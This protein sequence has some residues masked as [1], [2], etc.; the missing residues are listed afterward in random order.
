MDDDVFA[1]L[2]VAAIFMVPNVVGAFMGGRHS[3]TC[4]LAW[5]ASAIGFGAGLIASV[6]IS[7]WILW[8]KP[9]NIKIIWVGPVFGTFVAWIIS[10][11]LANDRRKA[12]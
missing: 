10:Q 11:R 1:M 2:S 6:L 12:A 3:N 7:S 9:Y 5:K 4:A 8:G